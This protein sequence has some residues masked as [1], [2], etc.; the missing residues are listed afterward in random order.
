MQIHPVREENDYWLIHTVC[1][2]PS[3]RL[4]HKRFFLTQTNWIDTEP[5]RNII[6]NWM[7]GKEQLLDSNGN[8]EP[9]K[10]PSDYEARYNVSLTNRASEF[11]QRV[12]VTRGSG[13][14]HIDQSSTNGYLP[15]CNHFPLVASST[16]T[17]LLGFSAQLQFL[18]KWNW[19]AS[20]LLDNF[21]QYSFIYLKNITRLSRVSKK[22]HTVSILSSCG[23]TVLWFI[24]SEQLIVNWTLFILHRTLFNLRRTLHFELEK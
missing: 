14:T 20:K 21:A 22:N 5:W 1:S 8:N 23:K 16:K 7:K 4:A 18:L 6:H 10:L 3:S 24:P 13:R 12:I 2:L 15:S 17:G 11:G 19:A 9:L